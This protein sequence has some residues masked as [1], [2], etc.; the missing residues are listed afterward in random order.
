LDEGTSKVGDPSGE[1]QADL[2][3][4]KV[5]VRAEVMRWLRLGG[6][7]M[8]EGTKGHGGERNSRGESLA[9]RHGVAFDLELTTERRQLR[10]K[11]T[12]MTGRAGLTGLGR[13]TRHGAG[14]CV[15]E[16]QE[17]ANRDTERTEKHEALPGLYWEVDGCI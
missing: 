6:L 10:S 16:S 14:G 9:A 2:V 15:D 5:I 1:E 3:K 17:K 4:G 11:C 8:S 7:R 12:D 13:E